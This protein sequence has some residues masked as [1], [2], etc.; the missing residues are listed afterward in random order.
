MTTPVPGAAERQQETNPENLPDA[1]RPTAEREASGGNDAPGWSYSGGGQN[2]ITAKLP[3]FKRKSF[4]FGAGGGGLVGIAVFLISLVAPQFALINFK[5]ILVNKF[6]RDQMSVYSPRSSNILLK[7]LSG[8]F[9][10]SGCGL[11]KVRCRYNG[12][13]AKEAAKLEKAGIKL[14]TEPIKGPNPFNRV[15]VKTIS[16]TDT[17]GQLKEVTP[18]Q[19]RKTYRESPVLR[20]LMKRVYNPR[21]ALFADRAALRLADRLKLF[22]GNQLEGGKDKISFRQ[23]LREWIRGKP[24][25]P[26]G[27]PAVPKDETPAQKDA[28]LAS[29]KLANSAG[30]SVKSEAAKLT[31]DL[32]AGK[33]VGAI[34]DIGGSTVENTTKNITKDAAKFATRGAILGPIGLAANGCTV[35]KLMGAIGYG[36]KAVANLQLIRYFYLFA[37]GA[38]A[39]KAGAASYTQTGFLGNILTKPDNKGRTFADSFGYNYATYGML[40]DPTETFKYKLGGGLTGRLLGFKNTLS[41]YGANSSCNFITNPFVQLGGFI[42]YIA[43]SIA[44]AGTVTAGSVITSIAGSVALATAFSV[45][46]I[47]VTPML[48][49]MVAGGLVTGDE[50]GKDA[51]NAIV[52]GAGAFA[53]ASARNRGL[54]PLTKAEAI[55]F[56]QQSAPVLAQLAKDQQINSRPFDLSNP[57]SLGSN[58]MARLSPILVQ[59]SADKL[60]VAVAKVAYNPLGALD[61]STKNLGAT[62]YAA[63][64]AD[65]Y[66]ICTDPEYASM[67][68]GAGL[69]ADP[70]CNVKY[71]FDYSKLNSAQYDPDQVINYMLSNNLIDNDGNPTGEYQKFIGDC[72]ENDNPISPSGGDQ[73]LPSYCFN[74]RNTVQQT[75]MRL[76]SIDASIYD[77]MRQQWNGEQLSA[78]QGGGTAT[79]T[80]ATPGTIGQINPSAA[81]LIWPLKTSDFSQITTPWGGY[82]TRPGWHTG[83]DLN[84]EFKPVYAAKAGTVVMAGP[85]G[86]TGILAVLIDHGGGLYTDYQH[87]DSFS[88]KVGDRVAAGQQIGVS[89]NS[90]APKYS[91]G[92]HLHFTVS[93]VP[94]VVGASQSDAK[95]LTMDPLKLLPADP[96]LVVKGC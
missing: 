16:F 75:M 11:V 70:F 42:G 8:N 18:D 32:A 1:S 48:V 20:N 21:Y 96:R 33:D 52:A 34:P 43:L 39:A 90:G 27:T 28:R 12:V 62:A 55:A 91:T 23:K 86:S 63:T 9:D 95:T 6:S 50:N 85:V 81:G 71:G 45:V 10:T 36:A 13:S 67:G 80:P 29:E 24:L 19:F 87:L 72:L 61:N 92:A 7:K 57:Y 65:E 54:V 14:T 41:Q 76:Y 26:G 60:A 73:S 56:D 77:G 82:C 68:G 74:D 40:G 35:Y 38:D 47:V 25:D 5:E 69:A 17:D 83:L 89:G 31:A 58:I 94:Y 79:G 37:N 66:N 51:G 53:S 93:K 3:F 15:K 59:P 88:V 78:A 84:A 49:R 4:I 46:Q 22:R 30:D 44:T 64:P 2:G